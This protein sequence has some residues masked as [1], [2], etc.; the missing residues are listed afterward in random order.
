MPGDASAISIFDLFSVGPGPSSSHTV[1]PMRAA[2]AVAVRLPPETAALEARLL[3]SLAWT[4]RGHAS[5]VAVLLGLAGHEPETVD[6][7]ADGAALQAA[8]AAGAP[9]RLANGAA[10]AF[11]PARDLV[12]DRRT[13]PS[14]H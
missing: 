12:L 4:G 1:G 5:D 14:L 7:P 8:L 2:R 6:L 9:L 13:R 10:I 11:D 3:G